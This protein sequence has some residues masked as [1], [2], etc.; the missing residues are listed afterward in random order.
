VTACDPSR[1]RWNSSTFVLDVSD[2]RAPPDLAQRPWID[3]RF[4]TKRPRVI[5]AIGISG[6]RI[7]GRIETGLTYRRLAAAGFRHRP[8]PMQ[9]PPARLRLINIIIS[10]SYRSQNM[11]YVNCDVRLGVAPPVCL[12]DHYQAAGAPSVASR[13]VGDHS[14]SPGSRHAA[15]RDAQAA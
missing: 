1:C 6:S 4:G 15:V 13:S 8:S 11:G 12:A 3:L 14:R 2:V 10:S 7:A 9:R 5:S